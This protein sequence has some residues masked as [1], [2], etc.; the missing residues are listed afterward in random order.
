MLPMWQ[1]R[2]LGELLFKEAKEQQTK[3]KETYTKDPRSRKEG[4]IANQ[5]ELG[6]RYVN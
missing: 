6:N 2:P 1:A 4:L 5:G 3:E